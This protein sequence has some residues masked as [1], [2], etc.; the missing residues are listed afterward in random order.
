[1]RRARVYVHGAFAGVLREEQLDKAYLFR[2]HDDYDG[3]PVSLALPLSP[4][5]HRFSGFPA[6]FEGLLPEGD[7]LEGLLRQNKIDRTD[8][9]AQLIAVGKDTVGA[10]TI[11]AETE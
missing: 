8:A 3:P 4:R 2:Y 10:V 6:F 5:E 9:F 11:E 7:M 1:M